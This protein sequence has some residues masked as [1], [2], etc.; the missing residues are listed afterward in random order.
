[1]NTDYYYDCC[2]VHV[3]IALSSKNFPPELIRRIIRMTI[4]YYNIPNEHSYAKCIN[5]I[6]AM[7][8]FGGLS[9]D[10]MHVD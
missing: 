10:T 1:M 9:F 5:N 7:L 8:G 6:R 3:F 4:N 2:A